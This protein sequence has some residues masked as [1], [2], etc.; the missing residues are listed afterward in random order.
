[1]GKHIKYFTQYINEQ[2][3]IDDDDSHVSEVVNELMSAII[4][5]DVKE[6]TDY[7]IVKRIESLDEPYTYDLELILS[8]N[9]S[10]DFKT[11][12]HFSSMEWEQIN[13]KK[14]GFS[15]DGN[16]YM[17]DDD[18]IVPEI[19]I[20]LLINPQREPE[21]HQELFFKLNDI[22]AHE[23]HH[24]TQAGWNKQI[25]ISKPSTKEVRSEAKS[26][27][28]YFLLPDE[29]EAMVKGMNRHARLK[30]KPIDVIF[31]EYLNAFLEHGYMKQDEH[32]EVIAS[33]IKYALSHYPNIKLT[34]KYSHIINKL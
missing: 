11:D 29:V 31:D 7:K 28:K 6:S 21:I 20:T 30:S 17:D 22:V 33:W 13:F 5:I 15:M 18:D 16:V 4:D 19:E 34:D 23:F 9:S 10:P 14:N 32:D 12:S 2:M 26:S 24:L 27:Y 1:M 3:G 25:S 8:R